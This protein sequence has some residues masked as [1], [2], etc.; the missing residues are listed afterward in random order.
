MADSMRIAVVDA[1]PLF[2]KGLADTIGGPMRLVV[3]EGECADDVGRIVRQSKPDMLILDVSVPGDGLAA[4]ENALRMS[5]NLKIVIVTASDDESDI[6]DALHIGAQGY[7]LKGVSA[8]E[9]L[10]ALETIDRGV[11]YVTPALAHRLLKQSKGKSLLANK[12]AALG[13]TA[14]D[15][16]VLGHLA[17]GL[18][19]QQIAAELGV[20][21]RTIKYYLTG[22]FR[23]MHVHTRVE[24]ILEA[25]RLRLDL[26]AR[27][28]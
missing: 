25:R 24:A 28:R 18:S 4:A 2:R 20:N 15:K 16:S 17:K 23:K 19:N 27:T 14:R 9:L 3:A 12:A 6:A 21:V 1:Q 7:I 13:L 11:P 8:S 26:D 22:I 10:S 5:P